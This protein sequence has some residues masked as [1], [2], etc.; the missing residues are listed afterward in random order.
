MAKIWHFITALKNATGNIIF[1]SL[2][3]L[4]VFV[5]ASQDRP[6]VPES[7]VMILDPEGLIVEQK[8]A[9][10]PFEQLLADDEAE[11]A[12]TLGRD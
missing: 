6:S 8:R 10:D 5:L 3:G 9:V 7:A 4:L 12:E 2:A 1:L 11:D